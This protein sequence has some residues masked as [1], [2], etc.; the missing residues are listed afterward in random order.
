MKL[1]KIFSIGI[2]AVC[3]TACCSCRKNKTKGAVPL[4]ET[5]WQLA[6]IESTA[7]MAKGE[8]YTV[9]FDPDNKI[10]G[11]GDCNRLMG[12][13]EIK[14]G[15]V[16][17]VDMVASTRMFCPDQDMENRFIKTLGS[18]NSYTIDGDNL[19]LMHDGDVKLV[20]HKK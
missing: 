16:I 7:H 6:T 1:A 14:G 4:T 5:Q 8:A 13:Y 19:M 12:S 10:T 2:L 20:M 3:V 15:G 18:V 17:S 9:V 11:T